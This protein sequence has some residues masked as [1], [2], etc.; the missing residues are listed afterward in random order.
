MHSRT[1]WRARCAPAHAPG[2][3]SLDSSSARSQQAAH[4][5]VETTYAHDPFMSLAHAPGE[6]SLDNSSARFRQAAQQRVETTYAHAP[7]MLAHD[8]RVLHVPLEE[9]LQSPTSITNL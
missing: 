3:D 6:D 5:R 1:L 8:G 9:R 4:Q 7:L 2:E